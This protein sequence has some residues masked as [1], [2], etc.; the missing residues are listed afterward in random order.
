MRRTNSHA[1]IMENFEV[2]INSEV[3]E[4]MGI[5]KEIKGTKKE[6]YEE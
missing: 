1:A 5:C 6:F 4:A 2:H 3:T